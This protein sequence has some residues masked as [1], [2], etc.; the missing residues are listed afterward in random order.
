MSRLEVIT[1][2]GI[3]GAR[4]ITNADTNV[5]EENLAAFSRLP[6]MDVA[7][8][9]FR[10]MTYEEMKATS[11]LTVTE[12]S[13]DP[14]R[15]EMNT[16]QDPRLGVVAATGTCKQCGMD[17]ATCNG[18]HSGLIELHTYL[19]P[20]EK[21]YSVILRQLISC[22]C[23]GCGRVVDDVQ[24]LRSIYQRLFPLRESMSLHSWHTTLIEE[25][26]KSCV[27]NIC[28]HGE[29]AE[30]HRNGIKRSLKVDS[31]PFKMAAHVEGTTERPRGKSKG[32]MTH[33]ELEFYY[34]AF[35][36]LSLEELLYLGFADLV[37]D[38]IRVRAHPKAL[39]A[40]AAVV[41]PLC[42]RAPIMGD[43]ATSSSFHPITKGY[44][45]L[46]AAANLVA[47][48]KAELAAVEQIGASDKAIQDKK[49][50]VQSKITSLNMVWIENYE[51][52]QKAIL[53][54]KKAGLMRGESQGKVVSEIGRTTVTPDPRNR[55]GEI[56]IPRK[57]VGKITVRVTVTQSNLAEI[58]KLL[59]EG[60]VRYIHP[61]DIA[62]QGASIAVKPANRGSLSVQIGDE[63]SR[64]IQVGDYLL[65]IR[66]PVL[67]GLS[68]ISNRVAR[69]W[70]NLSFGFSLEEVEIRAMDFD[71][72]QAQGLAP[73]SDEAMAELRSIN[74][75]EELLINPKDQG[76]V[77]GIHQDGV[78]GAVIMT[79]N[80]LKGDEEDIGDRG[81][82]TRAMYHRITALVSDRCKSDISEEGRRL[83]IVDKEVD[84]A[85]RLKKWGKRLYIERDGQVLVPSDVLLSYAFPSDIQ[86]TTSTV[87]IR[88]GIIYRG[89][90][91]KTVL[92]RT[93]D[94]LLHFIAETDREYA[95]TVMKDAVIIATSFL[96]FYG[97]S[98]GWSDC[99]PVKEGAQLA[100]G[101]ELAK[102]TERLEQLQPPT[103][104]SDVK[105][106]ETEHRAIINQFSGQIDRYTMEGLDPNNRIMRIIRSGAKGAERH[107]YNMAGIIGQQY[108]AG[109]LPTKVMTGGTRYNWYFDADDREPTSSGMCTSSLSLGITPA[110]A[111]YVASA[112]RMSFINL[113]IMTP[114]IG[115][116]SNEM[117]RV[118]QGVITN[119]KASCIDNRKVVSSLYG[120][121]GM[122][123]ERLERVRQPN[124]KLEVRFV[125]IDTYIEQLMAEEGYYR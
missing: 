86:F 14:S 16:P 91:D 68:L 84:F 41:M 72:D 104:S 93:Q 24:S 35:E 65:F 111:I 80:P 5:I 57:S 12:P 110:E 45:K 1:R 29:I 87:E 28:S 116:R 63:V 49:N 22:I 15:L 66:Q 58:T 98:A 103:D 88:D 26:A 36:R 62:I 77:F 124:G 60:S 79:T 2:A 101:M 4:G 56:S 97:I 121:D 39:I 38:E 82:V 48:A 9:T 11:I 120:G 27:S 53:S 75:A 8:I 76:L 117:Q 95:I 37:S 67:S 51:T 96:S 10:L 105:R 47:A 17:A 32:T 43:N 31:E 20:P 73:Q 6:T 3:R 118:L 106:Y 55:A 122:A 71:G 99:A 33:Y 50:L 94:T 112:A 74:S 34:K 21:N 70:D 81:Y 114:D 46:V 125:D 109:Q 78:L 18:G 61:K 92:G 108:I 59:R 30:E 100:I 89:I 19:A 83:G 123:P 25:I 64:D 115:D 44:N 69:I 107:L 52:I 13:K 23:A 54:N 102:M 42:S 40:K 90:V 7:S 85:R 119:M 113:H